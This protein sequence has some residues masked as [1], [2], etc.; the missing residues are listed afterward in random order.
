MQ[1]AGVWGAGDRILAG[2]A[3]LGFMELRVSAQGLG[4]TSYNPDHKHLIVRRN[5]P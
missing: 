2:F 4:F 1:G 3:G 5:T